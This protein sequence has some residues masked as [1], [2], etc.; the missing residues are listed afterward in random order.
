MG[1]LHNK[2]PSYFYKRG[3]LFNTYLGHTDTRGNAASP[4][5]RG[6][7]GATK[8]RATKGPQE[9][10]LKFLHHHLSNEQAD[11]LLRLL[12]DF[13][14]VPLTKTVTR[15]PWPSLGRFVHKRLTDGEA[16]RYLDELKRRKAAGTAL[17][18]QRGETTGS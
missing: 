5:R 3:N 18:R 16:A 7:E 15:S 1:G 6:T 2:F 8:P 4:S 10:L 13:K 14:Q 12:A 9:D 17:V 11:Q